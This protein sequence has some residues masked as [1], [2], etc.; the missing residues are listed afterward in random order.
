MLN[1]PKSYINDLEK[2]IYMTEYPDYNRKKIDNYLLSLEYEEIK[3]FIAILKLGDDLQYWDNSI[4]SAERPTLEYEY[5]E[6]EGRWEK[7][8]NEI[9]YLQSNAEFNQYLKKG[10][11]EFTLTK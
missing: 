3:F 10:L 9:R 6:L 2:L 8:E 7:I 1:I 5:Q 4:T 11:K